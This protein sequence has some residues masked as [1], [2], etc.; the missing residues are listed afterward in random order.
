MNGPA[1]PTD[2]DVSFVVIAYNERA[3]IVP[4]L[5]SITSQVGGASFEVVVVDDGSSD[6][7]GSSVAEFAAK[8]TDIA[9]IEHPEN[10]GRGARGRPAL[11]LPE[12]P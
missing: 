7:T 8:R 11:A 2:P 1:Q 3:N 6:G 10:R 12:V 9:L 5:T 4:C